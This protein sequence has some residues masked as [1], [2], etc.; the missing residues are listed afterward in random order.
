MSPFPVAVVFGDRSE[1]IKLAPV[2]RELR[3]RSKEV[4]VRVVLAGRHR[5]LLD[6]VVEDFAI[7]VDE[8]LHAIAPD[9]NRAS[10]AGALLTS[11]DAV[12]Q[13]FGAEWVVLEGDSTATVAAAL[14]CR[15]AGIRVCHVEAGPSGERS[16]DQSGR[17][18]NRRLVGQ[19]ADLHCASDPA[20]RDALCGQGVPPQ[21]VVV[22]GNP[23]VEAV[24]AA[25]GRQGRGL[26]EEL[27]Q[28]VGSG[29]LVVVTAQQ[30][31]NDGTDL[32]AVTEAV[33]RISQLLPELSVLW[34]VHPQPGT[35]RAL[36]S[37]VGDHARVQLIAPQPYRAFVALLR[38]ADLVLTDSG[39]VAQE[40]AVL[41]K[42]VVVLRAATEP[43]EALG[44]TDR[45]VA[46]KPADIELAAMRM[47]LDP[48]PPNQKKS[49]A[50]KKA[51]ART[52]VR[53]VDALLA[54]QGQLSDAAGSTAG[55]GSLDPQ[56]R[57]RKR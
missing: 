57:K 55:T 21:R 25:G 42:P 14:A 2:V 9:E 8:E 24:A 27:E 3:R 6:Q 53:I 32:E 37:L 56:P 15:W 19:L 17:E 5:E 31:V 23:V 43:F 41:E 39:T 18:M 11:L 50:S 54:A 38:G 40:A 52:S 29:P 20:V 30:R 34:P 28:L 49:A 44:E 4:D 16:Q 26:P 13:R 48:P 33:K 1:A 12:L 35:A 7:Q 47:L 22:C 51:T 46:S 10:A 45:L 36:W